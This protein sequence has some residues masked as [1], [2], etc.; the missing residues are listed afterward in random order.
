MEYVLSNSLK[1]FNKIGLALLAFAFIVQAHSAFGTHNRAGEITYRHISGLKYEVTIT[2]CTKSSAPADREYLPIRWGDEPPNIQNDSLKR[3]ST[4]FNSAGDF[5]INTYVGEHIYPGPGLYTISMKDPNRNSDIL[6]MTSSIG[7]AFYIESVLVIN[8]FSGG[9]NNSVQLLNP[10]KEKACIDKPW[11]HNPGAFDPD[12]DQLVFSLVKCRSAVD[13]ICLGYEFPDVWSQGWPDTFEID[14]VTGTISWLNPLTAGEYNVAVLVEEF[15]NGQ[16]VGSVLRD[17]QILVEICNN[18]PPVFQT[19]QNYC[20]DA[21]QNLTFSVTATDVNGDPVLLTATGGPMTQVTNPAFFNSSGGIFS[22]T[23][24]CAEI[25]AQPY[26]MLFAADDVPPPGNVSLTAYATSLITVVGPAVTDPLATPAGNSMLLD[27]SPNSCNGAFSETQLEAGSYKIYRRQ[28]F[29]GFVPGPCE[30]GVPDGI[31]YSLIGTVSGLTN[32]AF[33]DENV[34]YGGEYCYMVV[35][36]FPDGAISYASEEFCAIIIKDV[37][38]MTNASVEITDELAGQ[39]YVA[40]SPPTALDT[41]NFVGPYWY[42]LYHT[43][44]YGN[45]N[46]LIHT[47]P[48]SLT[49]RQADT[50]FVHPGINTST[51]AHNYFVRFFANGIDVNT[52]ASGASIFLTITPNDNELTLSW[53]EA[54]PWFNI[55]HEIYRWNEDLTDFE[56]IGTSGTNSYTDSNLIN[57]REYC[58]YVRAIG[59]FYADDII[60]PVI[61]LSQ[62][63]CGKPFDL[64]HPCAPD[65]TANSD[66]DGEVVVFQWNNPNNSCADDVTQYNIYWGATPETTP[67]LVYT[68]STATETEFIF[69]ENNEYGTIAGCFYVTALDSILPVFDGVLNQNESIPSNVICVDNCPIY[70]LPNVFSPNGDGI[71]DF[72]MPLPYK[73][74]ESVDMKIFNR[75]GGVIFET[76]D[77]DIMWN[78][79]SNDG[80]D[81]ASDGVYYYTVI[82]NTIRLSGIEPIEMS[83]YFHLLGGKNQENKTN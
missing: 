4:V 78:G 23:P 10:S 59:T 79:H 21:G 24:Q 63:V 75:W 48:Q 70:F 82:V 60:D 9:Y 20:I 81:I 40:W 80:G 33:V 32:A 73:F 52:A 12:G 54:W 11:Y 19:V 64:T 13:T 62:R 2:T 22:W 77:K 46:L 7:Q 55:Q 43:E 38:V 50:V 76:K 47:T 15:R 36:C 14:P 25:R 29:Y 71:N 17:M 65:L 66:C 42:E 68:S 57:N 61:N 53:P 41:T 31:G 8:P 18:D 39:V 45:P 1:N 27:W 6:N 83:G 67:V 16:F 37:P 58:Y 49:L 51:T 3:I 28:G 5:Q 56:L 72:F 69:N 30:L 74:I 34:S 26:I 44:G 35:T